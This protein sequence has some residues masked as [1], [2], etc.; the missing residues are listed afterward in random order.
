VKLFGNDAKIRPTENR[1]GWS[2][3]EAHEI[4]IKFADFASTCNYPVLDLGAGFGAATL[5]AL[6][7]GARVVANDLGP[8][9]I[10]ILQKTIPIELNDR[11]EVMTGHFPSD[12]CFPNESLGAIH[13]SNVLHFLTLNELEAGIGLMF[14]W[15]VLG[16]K[17]FVMATSP[18]QQNFKNFIP[19]FEKRKRDGE[20]WP[21]WVEDLTQYSSHPSLQFLPTSLNFFDAEVLSRA[22]KDCGFALEIAKEYTRTG[23]PESLKYDG[24]ENV[25]VVA[26]K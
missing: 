7:K 16:G 12:L 13:A 25:M 26:R 14:D 5:A 1:M 22:F 18:Y 24:R 19:C 10:E 6:R 8:N 15:L 21:G 17:V 2:S 4:N 3:E 11:L 20:R 9:Q 23:L